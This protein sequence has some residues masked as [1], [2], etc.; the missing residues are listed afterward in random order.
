MTTEKMTAG[1]ICRKLSEAQSI[2]ILTQNDL[3]QEIEN[4]ND[5]IGLDVY[6]RAL[7]SVLD[8]IGPCYDSLSEY[9]ETAP[10]PNTAP[11]PAMAKEIEA[12]DKQAW[13]V[14]RRLYSLEANLTCIV[15]ALHHTPKSINP[16]DALGT[17]IAETVTLSE[18]QEKLVD[19]I[20]KLTD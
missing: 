8:L 3:G 17:A 4:G 2:L 15:E 13:T 1:G 6:R 5:H 10:M 20:K 7:D 11:K 9:Q 18:I 16:E 12:L 14:Q 19:S